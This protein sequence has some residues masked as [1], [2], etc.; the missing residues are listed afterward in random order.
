MQVIGTAGHVDHGKSTLIN[1]MTGINPDRLKQEQDREMSIELG[2]AWFSL[3][4]GEEIGIIDVPGHRDFIENMLSGIGGIDAALFVVAADEGVMPQ[5]REHLAILDLLQIPAGVVALTKIDLVKEPEWLDLVEADLSKTLTGTVLE[6]APIV[7][8]SA[9]S[10]EGIDVLVHAIQE[11]LAKH[12]HRPDL[13]RPRLPVDRIFTLPGFGTIVTGTLLD[14]TLAVGD[15]VEVLPAGIEGRIRGL[16]THKQAEEKALPGSRT[17]VNISGISHDQIERGNTLVHPGTFK[18]TK[19][20]D[21]WC[22]LLPDVREALKQNAEIKLF[23]GAAEVMARVRLLGVDELAPGKDAFLQLMLQNP[24]VALRQDRFIIRRPSP[25]ATIGGGQVVDPHPA[26]RHKRYNNARLEELEHLLVGTPEDILLQTARKLGASSLDEMIKAS[27]L[28]NDL[29]SEAG[30]H[31]ISQGLLLEL[32]NKQLLM[33]DDQYN[34]LK[35]RLAELLNAFH[36]QNPLKIGMPGEQLKSQVGIG[37][38]LF[39]A[40]IKRMHDGLI[41]EEI[42]A[43]LRLVGHKVRFSEEQQ[44]K[45]TTLLDQFDAAPYTPPTV[46][47]SVELIGEELL[48]ALVETGQL[49]Q[50]GEDVL[51]QPKRYD[52]MK[53]AVI[54][55]IQTHGNISLA[56]LRDMFDTSRKYAVAVLEQLDQRGVTIRQGDV[57]K[58]RRK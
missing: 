50:L 10:G 31:L 33:S 39:D 45:V 13:G 28:E 4:N 5:T 37:T 34:L 38:T 15:L 17:A 22:T 19:M 8:V 35:N 21:V 6:N 36:K 58:L 27:G 55:H 18:P 3:P 48:S 11:V 23:I 25:P 52:E 30:D 32:K 46:K 43:K 51:L 53:D 9:R 56:E 54:S 40:L 2:F 26:K 14:G 1:R 7:R 24:I 20:I 29:A 41:L 42:G 12:P 16:Q 47:Q 49:M 57:R 44:R